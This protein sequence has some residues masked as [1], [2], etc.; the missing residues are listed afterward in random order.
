MPELSRF[1]TKAVIRG[2][3]D[4]AGLSPRKR[5][6]QCFL[7][8]RNLM[9]KLVEA[10]EIEQSDRI[11]EIG[12]GT[13]S[14]TSLL[15]A[16]ARHVVTVEVDEKIA[17]L[18]AQFLA[19]CENVTIVQVDALRNKSTVASEVVRAVEA[20]PG[21]RL[22][23]VANLPYDVATSLVV[24]LLCGDLPLERLCFTVQAEVADRFLAAPD[25]SEYGPVSIITQ[26]LAGV[27]RV[28]NLPPQAF[29]PAPKV[30]S[31]MLCLDVLSK[32]EVS[33]RNPTV[34][35]GFVRRFFQ[36]RRKTVGSIAKRLD[37][38]DRLLPALDKS[39]IPADT[40]PEN[41]SIASWVAFYH[42]SC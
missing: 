14:L 18:A 4:S 40:R 42:A 25:S 11:L 19:N 33:I 8:D 28:S 29:W 1:Q 16:R 22:K 27:R 3:L 21:K 20:A 13:G 17:A 15:A 23:L 37:M 9:Q 34:F 38:G 24:N 31:T 26:V 7:I 2:L 32:E 35:S 41:I 10:A 39:Q 36:F 12:T 6:G 30:S 5:Y